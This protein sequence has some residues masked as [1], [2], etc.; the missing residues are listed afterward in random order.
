MQ[1]AVTDHPPPDLDSTSD[2]E[3]ADTI[4]DPVQD[5]VSSDEGSDS[6]VLDDPEASVPKN[7]DLMS[8]MPV[9]FK[10][11]VLDLFKKQLQK[12][13][14][15][16]YNF[17]KPEK[18]FDWTRCLLVDAVPRECR[19]FCKRLCCPYLS[20]HSQ[21]KEHLI[22][23]V[24]IAISHGVVKVGCT[25]PECQAASE[26]QGFTVQWTPSSKTYRPMA[27]RALT[28]A[29]QKECNIAEP[30]PVHKGTP[31]TRQS[32]SVRHQL[33]G[34]GSSG[35]ATIPSILQDVS[36]VSWDSMTDCLGSG[37]GHSLSRA[38]R[39]VPFMIKPE[40]IV[41][42]EFK[43]TGQFIVQSMGC[44]I[45]EQSDSE[46]I[47]ST[48]TL[49]YFPAA[50]SFTLEPGHCQSVHGTLNSDIA[51]NLAT[52]HRKLS[53][54]T[55]DVDDQ[56]EVMKTDVQEII[57]ASFASSFITGFSPQTDQRGFNIELNGS[58]FFCKTSGVVLSGSIT[59]EGFR[60]RCSNCN[61]EDPT[62]PKRFPIDRYMWS[63]P[64]SSFTQYIKQMN[65]QCVSNRFSSLS[66]NDK[67]KSIA[68]L[69][70]PTPYLQDVTAQAALCFKDYL[71][72]TTGNAELLD[73][74]ASVFGDVWLHDRDRP[75]NWYHFNGVY[76]ERSNG[77][78]E[79]NNL[80][81][82]YLRRIFRRALEWYSDLE[83]R[84]LPHSAETIGHF[85]RMKQK[86]V[87]SGFVSQ[88]VNG[89]L[90]HQ[91]SVKFPEFKQRRNK[92]PL[93][94]V[95]RDGTLDLT[96]MVFRPSRPEDYF[97]MWSSAYY[98]DQGTEA[99]LRAMDH[100]NEIIRSIFVDP[101]QFDWNMR[102]FASLLDGNNDE[103]FLVLGI[104]SSSNGK[105]LMAKI[106]RMTLGPVYSSMLTSSYLHTS[107]QSSSAATPELASIVGSRFVYISE[108]EQ[109]SNKPRALNTMRIKNLVG[110][111]EVAFRDIY[112][113]QQSR[114][115]SIKFMMMCNPEDINV[116]ELMRHDSIRRRIVINPYLSKFALDQKAFND[117]RAKH[118]GKPLFMKDA[119]LGNLVEQQEY[120]NAMHCLMRKWYP[121]YRD[122]GSLLST[123]PS[124]MS[125]SSVV[126]VPTQA[127]TLIEF[128]DSTYII[129]PPETEGFNNT[130]F[131]IAQPVLSLEFFRWFKS[132]CMDRI[133]T[134]EVSRSVKSVCDNTVSEHKIKYRI[135]SI[136]DKHQYLAPLKVEKTSSSGTQNYR[137]LER[138]ASQQK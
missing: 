49:E 27:W 57:A 31:L 127:D 111:D 133:E 110:G 83:G 24:Y 84:D 137:G 62:G 77:N 95:T 35:V 109:K 66:E 64:S 60:F 125:Q 6:V 37:K 67:W 118:P 85:E 15:F 9:Y 13:K 59:S 17:P 102:Y 14:S 20:L 8:P 79:L 56:M 42:I 76:W 121:R 78:S 58:C 98:N 11:V 1:A 12:D 94:H 119:T 10:T 116:P 7:Q 34:T 101:D 50:M 134:D 87:D 130:D 48:F 88:L 103:Q 63:N 28:F 2:T 45:C 32:R 80:V 46:D 136:L 132:T 72:N 71:T 73:F 23:K 124:I 40:L 4:I 135:G 92:N 107:T 93:L 47:H 19:V 106:L 123:R 126:G 18:D 138:K 104:G 74:L 86:M 90:S 21:D 113:G 100:L 3:S 52:W 131:N 82:D 5:T 70:D 91:L 30:V 120:I 38:L 16:I 54:S 89:G 122:G 96:T 22:P 53:D 55:V 65:T 41:S 81:L 117:Y 129:H 26:E 112:Q 128:I 33:D 99:V 105:S 114:E 68:H 115:L 36:N 61:V 69:H 43:A 39:S 108:L 97:T 51:N 25:D 44:P 75:G 29:L